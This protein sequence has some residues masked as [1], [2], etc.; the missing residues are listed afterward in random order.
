MLNTRDLVTCRA[1]ILG[2]LGLNDDLRVEFVRDDEVGCLIEA[3]QALRS[4]G[5][6]IAD[7]GTGQHVFDGALDEVPD[8]FADRIAVGGKRSS[9]ETFV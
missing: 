2:E 3:W 4:A 9:E 8:Q 5:L 1:V 6:A 7:P